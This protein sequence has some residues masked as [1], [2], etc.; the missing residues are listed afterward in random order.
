MTQ[1]VCIFGVTGS[2]GQSTL[3]ILDRH[4]DKYTLFAVTAY[5]R[6]KEL[7]KYANS[8]SLKLQLY[9]NQSR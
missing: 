3:K 5:S 8:I 1:S 6:I 7:L 4:P 9:L 2:I